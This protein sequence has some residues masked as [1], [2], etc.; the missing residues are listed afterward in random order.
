MLYSHFPKY[1]SSGSRDD[2]LAFITDMLD[3]EPP[4][5][6]EVHDLW[7]QY[8]DEYPI[9]AP[10]HGASQYAPKNCGFGSRIA[11]LATLH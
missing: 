6:N 3:E 4:F 8:Y 2:Q 1:P 5:P 7:R 9:C 11:G 10:I